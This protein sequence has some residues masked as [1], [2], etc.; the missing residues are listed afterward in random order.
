[1]APF[2]AKQYLTFAKSQKKE[3]FALALHACQQSDL[4]LK[5]SRRAENLILS[6]ILSTLS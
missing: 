1:M 5:S 2:Q 4:E 6:E 3:K